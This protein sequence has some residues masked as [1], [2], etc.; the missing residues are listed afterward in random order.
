MKRL[1]PLMFLITTGCSSVDNFIN[2]YQP[3]CPGTRSYDPQ[4]CRGEKPARLPNFVNEAHKIME[5]CGSIGAD[6]PKAKGTR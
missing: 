6:C 3:L 4:L 1:I 5:H 2:T